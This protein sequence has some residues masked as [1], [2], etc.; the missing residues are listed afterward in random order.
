VFNVE[1]ESDFLDPRNKEDGMLPILVDAKD[2]LAENPNP[3]RDVVFGGG[4]SCK[5]KKEDIPLSLACKG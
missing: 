2:G 4:V 5:D 1:C 3:P